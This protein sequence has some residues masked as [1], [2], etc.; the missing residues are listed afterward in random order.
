MAPYINMV[1]PNPTLLGGYT[2]TKSPKL[3]LNQKVLHHLS[4][5][6]GT[7]FEGSHEKHVT[8]SFMAIYP[9]LTPPPSALKF[10][11]LGS[12]LTIH[13][14]FMQKVKRKIKQMHGS[15]LVI[16]YFPLVSDFV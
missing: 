2:I 6:Q 15:I 12:I 13:Q 5:L 11:L 4:T 9:M 1:E 14:F 7:D 10:A 3:L 16:K 8:L